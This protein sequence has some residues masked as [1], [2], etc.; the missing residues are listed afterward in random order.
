MTANV[1]IVTG[2]AEHALR[3]P[4]AA[5]R[6]HPAPPATPAA[7]GQSKSVRAI[8][9]APAQQAVY[10]FEPGKLQR[11]PV[12]LGLSDGNYTQVLSG[13]QEGQQVVTG[14][15]TTNKAA[16]AASPG[17]RRFGF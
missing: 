14:M 5:M 10:V 11:V 7:K 15:A 8:S 2:R 4:V 16:P 1:K 6:F 12:N 3:L 13:L 17:T 9:G